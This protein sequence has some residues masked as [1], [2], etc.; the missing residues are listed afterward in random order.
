MKRFFLIAALCAGLLSLSA[1]KLVLLHTN[2]THSHIDA[3][4]GI[5]GVLQRKAMTDSIRKAYKN[6]MLIDAGDIVQGTLY[7]KLFGGEVEF[8][9]ME[10]LGYD[11][12]ILGNH[13]FDNGMEMLEKYYTK[14]GP[15]KLASNYDFSATKLADRFEPYVIRKFSG[16][17]VGFF[18]L[19]LDPTG[20]IGESNARGLKHK[21]II[22]TA[23]SMA[24]LLRDKGCDL[25]VAVTHI[26]YTDDTGKSLVTDPELAAKT[27]GIDIIIGGHSHSVVTEGSEL[28]NIVNNLDGKPVLIAQTGRYGYNLGM[29][30]VDMS[31]PLNSRA[32]LL[33][34]KDVNPRRF[35]A[36]VQKYLKP[37]RHIV[38]SINSRVIA[39]N[40]ADML[41][42]KKYAESIALTNMAADIAASYTTRQLDS[43]AA[44]GMPRSVDMAVIN[45]GGIRVPF[46]AGDITEGQVL[47]AF[48][49][50]NYA[51]VVKVKGSDMRGLLEQ[52]AKQGGQGVSYGTW[53]ATDE[54]GNLKNAIVNFAEIDPERD[55]YIATLDYLAAG[56]DYLSEFKKGE[57]VWRDAREFVAPVMEY[58]VR[59]GKAGVSINPPAESRINRATKL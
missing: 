42:T 3:E 56:G 44:P 30:E 32:K 9:L 46:P 35:D 28:P 49:F 41:N 53:L 38:D 4:N 58:I 39:R 19:N 26:G 16:K 27:R 37:Y 40:D 12:Q 55:Y 48:P 20:I 8:P 24:R 1:Q 47:S 11:L 43:I 5:G 7:F 57:I 29:I 54:Q 22:S 45:A 18:G 15:I 34:V 23:D 13:E 21:D 25:V 50:S 52:V 59:M 10:K 36:S 6:V 2:D 33:P 31:N 17:K 51:V 14:Q